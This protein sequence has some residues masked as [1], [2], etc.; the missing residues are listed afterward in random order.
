[1]KE[2]FQTADL[3]LSSGNSVTWGVEAGGSGV[4][5]YLSWL[6]SELQDSLP[7]TKLCFRQMKLLILLFY[8]IL[9]GIENYILKKDLLF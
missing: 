7:Y 5:G 4:Q 8:L 1:M 2:I 3:A 6:H 9:N